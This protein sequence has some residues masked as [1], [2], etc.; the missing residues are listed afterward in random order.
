MA[1][2]DELRERVIAHRKEA[3]AAEKLL[4]EAQGKDA[5]DARHHY[6]VGMAFYEVHE[7]DAAIEHLTTSYNLAP[8]GET[9]ARI[10]LAAWRRGDLDLG[11]R[12]IKSALRHDAKGV[13]RA[14]VAGTKT[15]YL[16]ILSQLRLGRG[17]IASAEANARAALELDGKDLTALATLATTQLI[18]GDGAQAAKTLQQVADSAP[19]E[20]LSGRVRRE[21]DAAQLMLAANANLQPFA[22]ELAGISRMVV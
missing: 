18:Q 15:G 2:I 5:A 22:T 12:W 11:E 4:E 20:F 19:T 6:L 8:S 16:A 9:A 3:E 17:E 13:T 14:P 21:L 10:S 7:Q 1:T